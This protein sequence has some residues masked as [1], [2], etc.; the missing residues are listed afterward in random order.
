[1]TT[2]KDAACF[3]LDLARHD[4][5]P[6]YLTH[7]QLQKLLYYLQGWSLALR[8]RPFFQGRIEAWRNGPVV[9]EVWPLFAGNGK[10]PILDIPGDCAALAEGERFFGRLIWEKY[11]FYSPIALSQMTHKELPWLMA[12]GNLPLSMRSD[13]EIPAMAMKDYFCG[14]KNRPDEQFV[15][16]PDWSISNDEAFVNAAQSLFAK[17]SRA[18]RAM[19]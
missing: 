17:Y 3:M 12:R 15:G 19:A 13:E 14:V 9:K 5:E 11:K 10:Q 7:L 16:T 2:A 1:M 8:N 4:D 18:M 6:Q